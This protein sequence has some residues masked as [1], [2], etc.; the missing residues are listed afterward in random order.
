[1]GGHRIILAMKLIG[2]LA[3]GLVVALPAVAAKRAAPPPSAVARCGPPPANADHAAT[4]PTAT[5]SDAAPAPPATDEIWSDGSVTIAGAAIDYCAVAGTLVVHPKDWDD[6]AQTN[7]KGDSEDGAKNTQTQASMFYAAYFKRGAGASDRPITFLFNGGPGSATIWLHMG[8]FGP[9]RVDTTDAVHSA[10]APYHLV[11]NDRSLLDASD[12]V[13]ID[14]PGT[15]FSRVSGPDKDKSFYGVDEDA[16]AFVEFIMGFL[17]RYK[18]WNSP[19]YLFGESY[20]TT[21]AAVV[22]DMLQNNPGVDLNGVIML[23]QVLAAN[24]FPDQPK[25]APGNDLPYQLALPTYAA[26]AWYHNQPPDQRSTEVPTALLNEVEHFAMGDY[27][28]ALAAGA[29]LDPATREAIVAKLHGYTSLSENYLRR[30]DL[31]VSVDEFRQELLHDRGLVVGATDTRFEG[32]TLDR[33][34]R[35]AHYDPVDAA[36]GSAYVSTFNDYVRRV[37][38][39]G[40]GKTYRVSVDDISDKWS[41]AHVPPD[42]PDSGPSWDQAA[43]VMPDLAHAMKFNPLLKVQL[44]SGYFDLV[45]PY[46]EGAFEMRHLPIPPEL[47]GNIEYRC[48]RSGHMVYLSPGALARLHDNVADFIL[49]TSNVPGQPGPRQSGNSGCPTAD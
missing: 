11:N 15:G 44:N 10:P 45:T 35:R 46:F 24:L 6:T 26:T 38:K 25:T 37:L 31:R 27:A 14:A 1:M 4:K 13:F 40:E 32:H 42:Q 21:R 28:T 20:G 48:Y 8:A 3:L 18:R 30:A 9:W 2:I 36:I 7:D 49:R 43:N 5:D 17:S 16:H 41:F 19:K 23:S 12:L 34:S 22:I 47:R 33:L 39:Y 29:S